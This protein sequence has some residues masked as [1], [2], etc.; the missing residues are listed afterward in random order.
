MEGPCK[1]NIKSI[2]IIILMNCTIT[3]SIITDLLG[4]YK[5]NIVLAIPLGIVIPLD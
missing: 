4:L 1:N 5:S 2:V 3:I